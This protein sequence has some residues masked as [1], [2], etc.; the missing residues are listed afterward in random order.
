MKREDEG[1]GW[2]LCVCPASIV[3]I[4]DDGECD[5]FGKTSAAE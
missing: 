2:F 4:W 3:L 1:G 5:C